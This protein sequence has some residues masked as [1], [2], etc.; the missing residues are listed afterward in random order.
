MYFLLLLGTVFYKMLNRSFHCCDSLLYSYWFFS[1]CVV[2]EY[3][4]DL[5]TLAVWFL[6]LSSSLPCRPVSPLLS[7]CI[8]VGKSAILFGF[9]DSF[10]CYIQS[11]DNLIDCHS[12]WLIFF[13]F[14]IMFIF[15]GFPFV[16]F[17]FNSLL[18]FQFA[19]S[20]FPLFL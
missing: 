16:L 5:F 18:K 6:V 12:H 20:C 9:S 3:F 11:V 17:F 7:F 14:D 8:S 1:L 19:H 10:L 13:F 4:E 2:C 15:L